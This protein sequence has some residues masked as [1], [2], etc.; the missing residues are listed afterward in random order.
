MTWATLP[1]ALEIVGIVHQQHQH[2]ARWTLA[3]TM[4]FEIMKYAL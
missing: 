4:T 3:I 2:L 1:A